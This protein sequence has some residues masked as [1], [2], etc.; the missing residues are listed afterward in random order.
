[1]EELAYKGVGSQAIPY[2]AVKPTYAA[3]FYEKLKEGGKEVIINGSTATTSS[4]MYTVP[5]GYTYFVTSAQLIHSNANAAVRQAYVS[6]GAGVQIIR[7][8][9]NQEIREISVSF[10]LPLKI[11]QN[12]GI[13]LKQSVALDEAHCII[14][15]FLVKNDI[16]F[17]P[18]YY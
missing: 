13:Y 5:D 18:E 1:M 17:L 12:L 7:I 3:S 6:F 4:L 11:N 15:G 10:P 2:T 9:T 16:A 14:T 8:L